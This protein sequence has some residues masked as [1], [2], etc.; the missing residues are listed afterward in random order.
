MVLEIQAADPQLKEKKY[1]PFLDGFRAIAVY[2]VMLHHLF[3][4][5]NV[6]KAFGQ[7]YGCLVVL[8]S[9]NLNVFLQHCE[10]FLHNL[11]AIGNIGVDM[12]FV[13]SG[14]LITGLLTEHLEGD[15]DV[16]RFYIRRSFKILPQYLFAVIVAIII[17]KIT[18]PYVIREGL[19][20]QFSHAKGA[21]LWS[22]FFF[23][24]NYFI[25]VPMLVHTWSLVI[26]EHF[27][28]FY[29]IV[30]WLICLSQK[31]ADR[32]KKSIICVCVLILITCNLIRYF[33]FAKGIPCLNVFLR[34]PHHFQTTLFRVDALAMG[35]LLK[36]FE[37]QINNVFKSS[38]YLALLSFILAILIYVY[39]YEGMVSVG[40]YYADKWYAYTLAYLAPACM[41]MAASQGFSPLKY[42][43]E[44]PL[45]R[46]IG[47]NSYGMYLWHY[48]LIYPATFLV[49]YC[50]VALTI[51][52][53]FCIA[54]M[55]GIITTTTIERY[56]LFLRAK[57]AP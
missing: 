9:V 14:F 29:P 4:F 34:A 26:E 41:L 11:A 24:Q 31:D 49:P 47:R 22:Y 48:I 44:N 50:G 53:Y 16:K 40:G 32:R 5:F 6:H 55:V 45:L 35:C 8:F 10:Y 46:W 42:I 15:V 38:K 33:Y 3:Y 39:F 21:V 23:L 25:Q 52:L 13:I 17:Y 36:L 51:F 56:F 43:V 37:P 30:I 27:Y 19:Y 18:P 7:V 57:I 20:P 12:F 28:L 1:Y 2:W 54:T